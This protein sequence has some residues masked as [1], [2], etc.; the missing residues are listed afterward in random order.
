MRAAVFDK[1]QRPG[2]RVGQPEGVIRS[3]AADRWARRPDLKVSEGVR[4]SIP[5]ARPGSLA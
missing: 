4:W 3:R 5:S 2:G 1:C